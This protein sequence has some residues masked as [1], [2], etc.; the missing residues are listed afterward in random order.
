VFVGRGLRLG[1]LHARGRPAPGRAW[2]ADGL[3]D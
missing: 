2:S 3:E 1:L